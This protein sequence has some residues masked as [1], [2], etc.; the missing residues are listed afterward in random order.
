MVGK[1]IFLLIVREIDYVLTKSN[2]S[3]VDMVN[4]ND[5]DLN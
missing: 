5:K 3:F 1:T 2:P 4:S